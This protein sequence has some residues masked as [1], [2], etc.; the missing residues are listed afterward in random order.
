MNHKA[1]F[2]VL[3]LL[4]AFPSLAVSTDTVKIFY[5]I[6]KYELSPGDQIKINHLVDSLSDKD[7]L[8]IF[9][10]ADYLGNAKGNL[11][12]SA[13]RAETIKNYVLSLNAKILVVME[14]KGEVEA[15][16]KRSAAGE[17]L[18]RRADII[19]SYKP[20][21][22]PLVAEPAPKKTVVVNKE[23]ADTKPDSGMRKMPA[24]SAAPKDDRSFK[25]RMNDLGNLNPGS[26]ISF[27]ELTFQPGRHFLNPEAVRYV[28]AL[29]KYLKKHD[30]IVFE[31]DG[32][33]CCET[34]NF[35]GQDFDNG[36]FTLST[37]RAKF[38]YD[39]LLK[40]G[41]SAAR[42]SYKGLGRS[43]PKVWP[44]RTERDRYLNRRVEILIVSK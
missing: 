24:I 35:D 14:G 20:V 7:T 31:I 44:E 8:K 33:I 21:I 26:S 22:K 18:N 9:G 30:N 39:Y 37:N 19:K 11:V 16:A 23:P 36:E 15:A 34:R 12:L 2:L 25:D 3:F 29:L 40:N 28:N 13:N 4:K 43:K 27:E 38:I 6:N 5:D 1:I 42:M 41:I 17:P 32:H 10:Y